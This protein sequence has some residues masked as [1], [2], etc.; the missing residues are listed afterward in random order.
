MNPVRWCH[1]QVW[2][3]EQ[4]SEVAQQLLDE[5]GSGELEHNLGNKIN[6]HQV[7]YEQEDKIHHRFFKKFK[8]KKKL[9]FTYDKE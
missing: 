2:R 9:K 6:N 3:P 5:A 4:N 7:K 1:F 8:P